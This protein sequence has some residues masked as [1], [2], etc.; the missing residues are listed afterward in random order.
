VGAVRDGRFDRS[1]RA[2]VRHPDFRRL[3][4]AVGPGAPSGRQRLGRWPVR[5]GC[6]MAIMYQRVNGEIIVV[7]ETVEDFV[8][9]LEHDLP[10]IAPDEL[11]GAFTFLDL[12]KTGILSPNL[13]LRRSRTNRPASPVLASRSARVGRPHVL[14][15]ANRT[16][17]AQRDVRCQR[18]HAACAPPGTP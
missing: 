6:R 3:S 16:L 5:Y 12:P 11:A 1:G 2:L 7:C 18:L 10:I 15:R 17:A 13:P 4:S 14:P 9:A 8:D